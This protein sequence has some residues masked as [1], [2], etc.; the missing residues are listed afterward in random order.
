MQTTYDRVTREDIEYIT[1][2]DF[3][4]ALEKNGYKHI[5]GSYVIERRSSR[6]GVI[7]TTE[8]EACAIGQAALNLNVNAV[9]LGQAINRYDYAGDHIIRYNDDNRLPYDGIVAKAKEILEP[10]RD[11]RIPVVKKKPDVSWS[12]SIDFEDRP[13]LEAIQSGEL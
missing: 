2:G 11:R 12:A 1:I 5:R 3:L 13:F 10:Y 7:P 6:F 4:R 9:A 8:Y